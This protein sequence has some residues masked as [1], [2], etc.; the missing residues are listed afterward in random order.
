MAADHREQ[1]ETRQQILL[2]LRR[3]GAMT[4]AELSDDLG[5]GAVGV[6]QHLALLERDGLV[7][8]SG[9]R[10]A[11]GRPS[12]LYALT[13]AA[14]ALFPKSYDR[15]LLDALAFMAARG[16]DADVDRLFETRR[17]RLLT[18]YA[19]RLQGR[20]LPERVAELAAILNEQGYMCEW[21]RLPDGAIELVEHNCPIDCV[22][23]S[24]P[25]AC[26]HE[27]ML[28]EEL[29]SVPVEREQTIASEGQCCRFRIAGDA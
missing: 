2:L 18:E 27:R 14:E 5:I 9:V 22:A 29:L 1:G 6:R 8:T 15:L 23:R 19:P 21:R 25:Q 4:A 16:G 24:Y 28:Y 17:Q 12:H 3:R 13:D 20:S 10:R 26:A 7:H 11:I